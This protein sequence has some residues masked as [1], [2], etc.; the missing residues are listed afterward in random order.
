MSGFLSTVSSTTTDL[1][2]VAQSLANGISSDQS[3]VV[4]AQSVA[5]AAVVMSNSN[6]G[7]LSNSNTNELVDQSKLSDF[8]E[9]INNGAQNDE[10][11][12]MMTYNH[13][14]NNQDEDHQYI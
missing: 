2:K 9:S 8:V 14:L 7:S 10:D 12:F 4:Y 5:D 6:G 3:D 11:T 13:A 1:D